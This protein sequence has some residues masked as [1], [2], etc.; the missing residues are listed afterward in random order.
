MSEQSA[1][2]ARC[3]VCC[4]IMRWIGALVLIIV[5]TGV[6]AQWEAWASYKKFYGSEYAIQIEL[7]DGQKLQVD[8][9]SF[10]KVYR[11]EQRVDIVSNDKTSRKFY[12]NLRFVSVERKK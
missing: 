2:P 7:A 9:K 5:G 10:A 11:N 12:F 3:G 8:D 4:E 6:L 1:A